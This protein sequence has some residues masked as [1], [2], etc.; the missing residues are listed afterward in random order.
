MAV[1]DGRD[2]GRRGSS[3]RL[4]ETPWTLLRRARDGDEP[5][6]RAALDELLPLYYKPVR[7]FFGRV[8][9]VDGQSLDDVTQDFF[10]RFVEK[11]FVKSLRHEKS[12]RAFVKVCC[13]RHW[14]NWLEAK[15][16]AGPRDAHVHGLHDRDGAPLDLAAADG[17][18]DE[19]VDAEMLRITIDR[20]LERLRETLTRQGKAVYL[21]VFLART[22]FDDGP[23][24][25]Y[26]AIAEQVGRSVYDV[27][28]YLTHARKVFRRALLEVASQQSDRPRDELRELGLLRYLG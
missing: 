10:A 1:S 9:R 23:T 7:S 12:F 13:R 8:L 16:R 25:S 21:E 14:I 22:R 27:R 5:D 3:S 6:R 15:R 4:P 20:A 17:E 28:N 11:E 19:L 2:R 18:L 26:E 24:R